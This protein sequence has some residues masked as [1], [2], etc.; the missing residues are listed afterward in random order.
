M[1]K[2][3]RLLKPLLFTLF[4]LSFLLTLF[5][6]SGV[7]TPLQRFNHSGHFYQNNESYN[8]ALARLDNMEK[9]KNYCD[10]LFE[11]QKK[12]D[13]S[14][15]FERGYAQLASIIVRERFFHGYSN[16]GFDNNY[17]AL[18]L[19]PLT[20]KQLSAIVI[21]DD[22]MK[23]PYAACSQQSIVFMELLK[24][25]G[26]V[27]RN[28]IFKESKFGGHYCFEVYYSG[29]WHFFDPDLEPDF[30]LLD[31]Y[32]RPSIAELTSNESLL[33]AAYSHFPKEKVMGVFK[34][35]TYG[36]PGKFSAPI[37]LLYQKI[38]KFLSYSAW[39]FFLVAFILV[40]RKYLRLRLQ[41]NVRNNRIHFPQPST[42]KSK[43]SYPE[44]T[45]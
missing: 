35:F 21:P 41:T 44:F 39:I 31:S 18:V 11:E 40:R 6:I 16:Y 24:Q 4:V 33:L 20:G 45:A 34:D 14:I 1:K 36:K 42:G 22:I 13:P 27:S 5:E 28:I 23:Y 37:A 10:S 38:T 30:R 19:E 8:P 2:I 25:K 7:H 26:Y 43:P 29:S 12:K 9:L 17:M 32:N 3:M 15:P